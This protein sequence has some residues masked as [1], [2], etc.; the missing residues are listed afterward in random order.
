[1]AYITSFLSLLIIL[2]VKKVITQKTLKRFVSN[3]IL[4]QHLLHLLAIAHNKIVILVFGLIIM[5]WHTLD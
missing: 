3:M 1:M 5:R 4:M 2:F